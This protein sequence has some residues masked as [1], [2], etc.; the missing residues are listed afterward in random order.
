MNEF[1]RLL[2]RLI[3]RP[4]GHRILRS[5]QVNLRPVKDLDRIDAD[6]SLAAAQ[7]LFAGTG[8][9]TDRAFPLTVML[10]T[11]LRDPRRTRRH[12]VIDGPLESAILACVGSLVASITHAVESGAVTDVTVEVDDDR[13]DPDARA[14]IEAILG[15]LTVPWTLRTPEETLAGPILHAQFRRAAALDR[16]VYVVEDDYLHQPEAIASLVGFYRQVHAATG[17]PMMLHPQEPRVLYNRHYPSYLVLGPD[18]RWRTTRHM[19]HTLFTHGHVVRDHWDDVEN[20]RYVGHP[21]KRQAHKGAERNTTNRV[22]R[23]L[24]GFCPIPALAAHFQ[25]PE[26]L[27]P[28]FDWTALFAAHRPEAAP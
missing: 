15:R 7:A 27:P 12:P 26:L 5:G 2:D 11:C 22:L 17:G 20:T 24:P 1:L 4:Q 14:A 13:S 3:V 18:R 6:D 23:V 9:G 25:A 16:L 19:S 8:D 21:T 28:F 10:R